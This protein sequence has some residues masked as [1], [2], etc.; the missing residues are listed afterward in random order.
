MRGPADPNTALGYLILCPVEGCP[1]YHEGYR[2]EKGFNNHMKKNH[3]WTDNQLWEY[4]KKTF[5]GKSNDNV[6]LGADTSQPHESGEKTLETTHPQEPPPTPEPQ[7]VTMDLLGEYLAHQKNAIEEQL[8]PMRETLNLLDGVL[9]GAPS[10]PNQPGTNTPAVNPTAAPNQGAEMLTLIRELMK[11]DQPSG[12]ENFLKQL[13]VYSQI[14]ALMNPP[15]T[16]DKLQPMIMSRLLRNA[17]L[18][19]PEEYKQIADETN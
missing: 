17:N 4:T 18:L 7:Y 9:K 13:Q 14:N 12:N 10:Q 8:A 1:R 11:G 6:E 5:D 3:K 19:T 2:T 16:L 15:T